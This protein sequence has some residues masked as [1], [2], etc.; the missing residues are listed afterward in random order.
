MTYT[1]DENRAGWVYLLTH[2]NSK[3]LHKIGLTR[4][5][6][7]RLEQ[8][9]GEDCT[10]IARVMASDPEKL[11]R[12]LHEQF[13]A[14]RIPQTEYFNLSSADVEACQ[15]VMADAHNEATQFAVLPWTK[16]DKPGNDKDSPLHERL[17]FAQKSWE[18]AIDRNLVLS[19]KLRE[20]EARL[21]GRA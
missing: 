5:P 10:V 18:D 14:V 7:R 21:C 13:A 1:Q 6:E 19:A 12:Q 2:K 17:R 9:G 3:G 16:W 20:L 11:E 15:D 8:L 4:H